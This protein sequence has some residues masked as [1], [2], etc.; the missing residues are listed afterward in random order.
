M[1][2]CVI[3]DFE[4]LSQDQNK[5][6]VISLAL[7]SYTEKR[8]VSNPYTY[9]ELLDNCKKIKFDVAEQV[10]T[11]NRTI[12]KETVAWWKEQNKEAQKQLAPS[13]EDISIRYLHQF[14]IDNIDL[15]N[16]EKAF[17]RGNTFDPI[18]MDS[19]LKEFGQVNPMHWGSIRDTRSF[20]DGLA[21][22]S[23]LSNKFIPEGLES[24]FI[25]HDPCHDIVMDVMRMQTLI[26]AVS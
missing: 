20:I 8:F 18:F 6:V 16:H 7:L 24:K 15:K 25:P 12:S 26:Q 13:S 21:Y 9:E 2:E 10:H 17:T 14:L 3:Y 1:N 19:L 4:T 11:Y 23:K 5:G 22:G